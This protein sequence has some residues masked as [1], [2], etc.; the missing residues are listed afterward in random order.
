MGGTRIR[1]ADLNWPKCYSIW[2][3]YSIWHHV[4]GVLE[5]GGGRGFILLSPAAWGQA[6]H[7]LGGGEQLFVYCLL[8]MCFL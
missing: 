1:T 2:H 6:R 4:E 3:P 8:N 7:G 5:E